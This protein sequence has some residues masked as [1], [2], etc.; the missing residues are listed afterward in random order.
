MELEV[1]VLSLMNK[2]QKDEC[3]TIYSYVAIIWLLNAFPNAHLLK[4]W[5]QACDTTARREWWCGTFRM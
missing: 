3:H 2:A 5:L 4:A 1:I